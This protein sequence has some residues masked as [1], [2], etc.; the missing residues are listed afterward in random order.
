MAGKSSK[1]R[2]RVRRKSPTTGIWALVLAIFT[3]ELLFVA[4]CRVQCVQVGYQIAD[5]AHRQQA[6]RTQQNS[7]KIELARLKAPELISRIAREKFALR[8]PEPNQIV[9]VP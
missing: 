7:L 2:T 6:L 8:T 9:L 4:W 5:E 1:K 3:V